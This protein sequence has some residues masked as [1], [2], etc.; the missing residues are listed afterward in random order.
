MAEAQQ[1]GPQLKLQQRESKVKERQFEQLRGQLQQLQQ[2]S[3]REREEKERQ[4]ELMQQQLHQLQQN[5]AVEREENERQLRQSFFHREEIERITETRK[6][7]QQME[8]N[9]GERAKLEEQLHE[10]E[11]ELLVRRDQAKELQCLEAAG[12]VADKRGSIKLTW[13]EGD[14]AP[15]AYRRKRDAIADSY[16]VYFLD[17]G[18][19]LWT[20]DISNKCW[21][22]LSE[23]PYLNSSL[24]ILNGLPTT[25]GGD[26]TDKL[27]SYTEEGEWIEEFPPMQAKRKYVTAVCIGASLILAGG[28]GERCNTLTMVEMLDIENHQWSTA[29]DLP[30]SLYSCS[31]TVCGDQLYMLGGRYGLSST[32]KSVYTCSVKA[33]LQ[34]CTQESPTQ[35]SLLGTIKRALSLSNSSSGDTGVWSK[36]ADLPVTESTCVTFCGQLLVK[37]MKT[38]P[39][40]LFICTTHP[41]TPG[42]SLV[43]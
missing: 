42:V 30:K 29:V 33:L 23:V 31:A 41:P 17:G 38:N 34:T 9:V 2:S 18:C 28:V 22:Q 5:L 7:S 37:S 35:T 4:L 3:I 16:K 6:G 11:G 8:T 32:T 25:I 19:H 43:T 26:L 24:A 12:N 14:K 40:Q 20:Y 15:F 39:P 13:R 1:E 27:M 21:L 10:L 36:L